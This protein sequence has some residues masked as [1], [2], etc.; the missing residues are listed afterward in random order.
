VR[1]AALKRLQHVQDSGAE[2]FFSK[3]N[4]KELFS[5]EFGKVWEKSLEK[6]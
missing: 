5:K 6:I 3:K 1:Y 4:S 2:P